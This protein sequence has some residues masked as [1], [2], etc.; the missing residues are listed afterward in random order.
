MDGFPDSPGSAMLQGMNHEFSPILDR[1]RISGTDI[2]VHTSRIFPDLVEVAEFHPGA[3]IVPGDV[4]HTNPGTAGEHRWGSAAQL[5]HGVYAM[6]EFPRGTSLIQLW[7]A[8]KAALKAGASCTTRA[9]R[10]LCTFWGELIRADSAAKVLRRAL[11]Q[12]EWRLT[13]YSA[14]ARLLQ[15]RK[16]NPPRALEADAR[17]VA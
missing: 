9:D 11:P 5:R 13:V 2:H 8:E 17:Y 15:L 3:P 10:T 14:P 4:L 6:V 1:L 16:F 7:R 12:T